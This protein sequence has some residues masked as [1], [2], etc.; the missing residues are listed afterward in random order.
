M[1]REE[2]RWCLA[3]AGILAALT[4]LPYLLGYAAQGES[5]RFSGF[6]FAVEDGNSYIAKM[7]QGSS[8]A[9]LFRSPYTSM[10]QA[11]VV[12]FLPYILLGKLAAG[13][14]LHEQLVVLFHL[15]RI[16]LIF[17]L[18]LTVYRFLARFIGEGY[19]RKWGTVLATAG[20]GLGWLLIL[21]GKADWLGS[22]PLDFISPETFGFLGIYGIPHLI[23]ARI[24]LLEGLLLYLHSVQR[25]RSGWMAGACFLGLC[26]VQPISAVAGLA[27]VAA[28]LTATFS[29][30]LGKAGWRAWVNWAGGAAR[31]VSICGP[32][33]LYYVW[34]F[35]HDPY[36]VAWTAQNRILSPP[37][38]HYLLA[39]GL[40]L[41]PAL[42]GAWFFLREASQTALL[43]V[44]WLV[45]FPLLAYAPHNLQRRLPDGIWVALVCLSAA[46][47]PRL[48]KR[49]RWSTIGAF[50]LALSLPST[51]IL[52]GG[53]VRVAM[54]PSEPAFQPVGTVRAFAWL[55]SHA[56]VGDV[57]LTGYALGNALPAWAPLRVV[58]GHGPESV[59]LAVLE[60]AVQ[61]FF[62]GGMSARER[63]DFL[64][65]HRVR[66]I[67]RGPIEQ[68]L[69]DW[70]VVDMEGLDL[71]YAE[72]GYQI[73]ARGMP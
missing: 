1:R 50:F 49:V 13:K 57:V 70:S 25:P 54:Q 58:I 22:M 24:L 17:P 7:L 44:A 71:R 67:V 53:G 73:F 62:A 55:S 60:Q 33:V 64:E 11:G 4:T 8:G 2:R 18:V 46:G 42:A 52:L 43:P 20:G 19:W 48:V 56:E 51:L 63:E 27:V 39:F 41:L 32:F 38:A 9:W 10:E 28:H 23:L 69:G 29:Y 12:A 47:I 21:A 72:S 35:S 45:L 34:E 5:W 14:A 30:S 37:P 16:G 26:L 6:V 40:L 31:V 68:A 66:F 61:L 65:A 15:L 3:Y 59:D 36:L